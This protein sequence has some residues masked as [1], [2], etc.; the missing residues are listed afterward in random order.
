VREYPVYI[1]K[2]RLFL[3]FLEINSFLALKVLVRILLESPM[4][5]F[6]QGIPSI[7]KGVGMYINRVFVS[8]LAPL[9]QWQCN[10]LVM[11]RSLVSTR[12]GHH[13]R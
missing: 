5:G 6:K 12:M 7:F 1:A 9:A 3:V 4:G 10:A 8:T 11:H 2:H 13:V